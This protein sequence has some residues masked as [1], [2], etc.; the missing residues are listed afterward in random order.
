MKCP[1]CKREVSKKVEVTEEVRAIDWY[2]CM[3]QSIFHEIP[4]DKKFFGKLYLKKW[5]CKSDMKERFEYTQRMYAPLIE[6]LTFGR[7]FLDVG[8]TLPYAIDYM[9]ER[10]WVSIGI[11]LVPNDY[12][13]GD[14]EKFNLPDKFDYI[15]MGHCLESFENPVKALIKAH[16]SLN[17]NGLLLITHPNPEMTFEIPWEKF[18][19]W[20]YKQSHV[21][22]SK[23]KLEDIAKRIGFDVIMS[24]RNISQR[25]VM[26][27]DLHL[28]LQRKD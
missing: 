27:N 17:Y 13:N 28:L 18:G 22:I 8:F 19:H 16:Q 20:D 21:F 26:H 14:F 6:E 11:D 4:I 15:F 25:F 12:I 5:K 2:M 1:A 23:D 24:H 7:K 10:G 3:C 9:K